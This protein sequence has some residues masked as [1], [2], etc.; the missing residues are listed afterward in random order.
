VFARA[1]T[2]GQVKHYHLLEQRR[3]I[4]FCES[5]TLYLHSSSLQCASFMAGRLARCGGG[6][7]RSANLCKRGWK[8]ELSS[9]CAPISP[10]TK[11]CSNIARFLLTDYCPIAEIVRDVLVRNA[12]KSL[13]P[14][15]RV[16]CAIVLFQLVVERIVDRIVAMVHSRPSSGRKRPELGVVQLELVLTKQQATIPLLLSRAHTMPYWCPYYAPFDP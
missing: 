7:S 8:I 14:F 2:I 3:F 10:C 15:R 4:S 11:S 13:P 1:V 5:P 12:M 9:D 6:G 16:L